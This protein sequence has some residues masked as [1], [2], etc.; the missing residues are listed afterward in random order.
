LKTL[1]FALLSTL[2]LAAL[3]GCS[4]ESPKKGFDQSS[5]DRQ[6]NAAKQA[7]RELDHEVQKINK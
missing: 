3:A 6:Q 4:S 1:K 2:W 7:D 5:Y